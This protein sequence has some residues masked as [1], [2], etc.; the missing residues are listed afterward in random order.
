[1]SIGRYIGLTLLALIAL[2]CSRK[3]DPLVARGKDL[4]LTLTEY[5][6]GYLQVIRQPN[7]FDSPKLRQNFLTELVNR[8][9]LAQVAQERH[10]AQD[11]VYSYRVD[12]YRNK[13]LRSAHYQQIIKPRIKYTDKDE[14][15]RASCRERV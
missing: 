9:L 6:L 12:A 13:C 4:S 10:Y 14:I 3:T 8:R 5:K 15:G 1:M 11:E 7:A 2:Q